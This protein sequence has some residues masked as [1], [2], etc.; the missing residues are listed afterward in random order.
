M[1]AAASAFPESR[2]P[3]GTLYRSIV[4]EMLVPTVFT[5][6]ILTVLLLTQDLLS[7]SDLVINRGLGFGTVVL[8]AFY[9]TVPLVTQ[10]LPFS[11]LVGCLMG[12]G[13]L[14]ADRE[15]LVLEAS[16]M[17]SPRLVGPVMAYAAVVTALAF[18]LSLYGSP[19][20]NRRLDLVLEQISRKTPAATM[21][22][23]VVQKFGDWK[24]EARE[25]SPKGDQLR[26]V[27]VWV[28]D[29]GETAF[30][31]RGELQSDPD[32]ARVVLHNGTMVFD[33]RVRPRALHFERMV[34]YLESE[35][36]TIERTESDQMKGFELAEL[37]GFATSEM[38]GTMGPKARIELHRRFA[39]PGA[40]LIFGLLVV[41]LFFSRA[42]VSRSGGAIL[43]VLATLAYYGLVQ[44][45][46][47]M[48]QADTLSIGTGVWLPNFIGAIAAGALGLRLKRSSSAFGRYSHRPSTKESKKLKET[49]APRK[50]DDSRKSGE[51]KGV[52]PKAV[53]AV[54]RPK[55]WALE[56]YVAGRFLEILGLF[57]GAMLVAYFLVDLL[58]RLEWFAKYGP[59]TREFAQ[60]YGWRLPLLASRVIPMALL[61]AS[62]LTVSLLVAQGEMIGMRACGIPAPRALAPV[63]VICAVVT[64]LYF[65]LSDEVLPRSNTY[66]HQTQSVIIGGSRVLRSTALWYRVGNSVC[67]VADR[68]AGE[69]TANDIKIYELGEDSRPISRV[70]A[71]EAQHIGG[72]V[73]R[74]YD[75]VRVDLR[76]GGIRAV[77]SEHFVKLGKGLGMVVD[78]RHFSL[79]EL[80]QEIEEVEA[81]GMDATHYKV[82]YYVKWA[83]PLSCIVLPT[84]A[85][86][87]AIGGPPSPS[88]A[89]TG[90]VSVVAAVTFIL[91]TGVST[92]LGYGRGLDPMVAG[93]GPPALFGM[94]AAYL[95]FRLRNLGRR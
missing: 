52:A 12:L 89:L 4:A 1:M 66:Y 93:W 70:D 23:G 58:E 45:G 35:E 6:A 60:F 8:I 30:A 71:V 87:F 20:C 33:P 67:E 79:A 3:G 24:L 11:L 29:A 88:A 54:L 64:L 34:T 47:G 85:L 7:F 76:G 13:R 49:S 61:L 72:Q 55:R 18:V 17:S 25:V 40:A 92:S 48:I 63:F 82:D 2:R 75:P 15:L 90:I 94:I 77:P 46:N 5:L 83:A 86:L 39:L 57:F 10:T 38:D 65:V 19:W 56:R 44:L 91:A 68:G 81:S 26:G 84:L 31:E 62:G 27:L 95:G 22:A 51:S 41:P 53:A 74:L 43:G 32:G 50:S 59:S 78:T 28:P 42:H 16:G 80:R 9:Q 37:A 14:G 69:G 21:S 73:W 36:S